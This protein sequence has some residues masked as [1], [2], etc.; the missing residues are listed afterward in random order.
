MD[1]ENK[2][3]RCIC[4]TCAN[5]QGSI[6]DETGRD[7]WQDCDRETD[8]VTQCMWYKRRTWRWLDDE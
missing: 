2:C 5:L 7:C 6:C 3:D 8:P 1:Y 4:Q